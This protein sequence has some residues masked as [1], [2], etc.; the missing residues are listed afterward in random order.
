MTI[1]TERY[2]IDANKPYKYSLKV[3]SEI[4]ETKQLIDN[5][6]K[7]FKA[8]FIYKGNTLT[9]VD[10]SAAKEIIYEMF[11][12]LGI[13][14][15]T[16]AQTVLKFQHDSKTF[17]FYMYKCGII[18]DDINDLIKNNK[19]KNKTTKSKITIYIKTLKPMTL[20]RLCLAN[21]YDEQK[22]LYHIL[23]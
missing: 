18:E 19:E 23:A 8:C 20:T 16:Q 14:S 5:Y 7:G 9:C 13:T 22:Y 6:A 21:L 17:G 15:V 10:K 1:D 12:I 2:I 4:N 11:E 3:N